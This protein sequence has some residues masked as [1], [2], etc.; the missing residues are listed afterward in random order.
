MKKTLTRIVSVL[1]S[2]CLLI[3]TVAVSGSGVVTD[4]DTDSSVVTNK[5]TGSDIPVIYLTGTGGWIHEFNEDGT[6]T[7]VFP[8][9]ISTEQLTA[10]VEE[11]ID[12]FAEAFFTQE[13]GEFCD[14]LYEI[15]TDLYGGFAL[16]ENGNPRN[17]SGI[18]WKWNPD[19]LG[20]RRNKYGNYDIQT[21]TFQYDWRLDPYRIADDLHRYIED[22]M[23]ATGATEVALVGR[24]LGVN[25][26]AAYMDKYNAEHVS[27]YIAY[28]GAHN[29]ADIVSKIFSGQMN[30]EADGIERFLYDKNLLGEGSLYNELLNSFVTVF[31]Q[32]YGLDIACW[33]VNNVY[34]DIY[35][36]IVPRILIET[37]ATLPSYWSMVSV[38]DYELA[39]EVVFH[40]ADM[41]KY[42]NFI[43][44][45]DNYHYNVTAEINEDF[46]RY[47]AMG[48]DI[49]NVTKYGYQSTPVADGEYND[50]LS[51]GIVSVGNSSN[52][53]TTAKVGKTFNKRY[54]SDAITN[55]KFSYI[56][57]DK[58]IDA[59]TA[60]FPEQTWF[61]K[62]LRH[63]EFP[64]SMDLLFGEMIRNEGYTVNSDPDYPQFMVYNEE[65]GGIDPLTTANQ[66]TESWVDVTF[67]DSLRK[68]ILSLTELIKQLTAAKTSN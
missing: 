40:G 6:T 12:V 16:D 36:D 44:I 39:K 27:D 24:C 56:S 11:N 64:R 60:Q 28:S 45:I 15:V 31:N 33:A 20:D 57:P 18:T 41:E 14:V 9:D 37:Y 66:Q 50:T 52:G 43:E 53:A 17:N 22:V 65:T 13:W 35:L 10:L 55:G 59:S 62:N 63:A 23:A 30:L 61:V 42:A 3:S 2:L 58:Q 5:H 4:T 46:E 25:I 8:V 34:K 32:T 67:F 7:K 49:F 51:D 48:V 26:T 19:T 21:Y 54:V 1:I 47:E 38:E 29:G 68:F